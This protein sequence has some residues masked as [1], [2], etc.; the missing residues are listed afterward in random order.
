M[1]VVKLLSFLFLALYFIVVGLQGLG[2]NLAF[3]H[4]GVLGFIALVAG[5]LFLY[6]GVKCYCCGCKSCDKP[7]DKYDK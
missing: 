4:P 3:V 2:V 1:N 7:Y 5:L 6:R